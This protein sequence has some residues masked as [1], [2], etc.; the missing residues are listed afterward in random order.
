MDVSFW[1]QIGLLIF[2]I[3]VNA[4][5]AASEIALI[6]LN[7]SKIKK[8]AEDGNKKARQIE[9]LVSEPSKFLATIQVGVTLSGF[10]A[11]AVAAD[12]FADRMTERLYPYVSSYIAMEVLGG[13]IIVVITLLLSYFTL[14]FGEL[15]P[16]RLAMQNYEKLSM[17]VIA[18]LKAI[19]SF[20]RPLY[21]F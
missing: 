2:L 7:D 13:I 4:F 14:V 17:M 18:P 3:G 19:Q 11:S 15:V 20:T 16:K 12:S 21:G 10:L 9:K 6:S 5:F 1:L 8:L